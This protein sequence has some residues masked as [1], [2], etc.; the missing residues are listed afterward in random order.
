MAA[1]PDA[2]GYW[3]VANDGG[4]F[5]F[6]DARFDG[7]MGGQRLNAAVVSMGV[8]SDGGGY[9][10]F[11]ADGGVFSFGSAAFAGSSSPPASSSLPVVAGTGA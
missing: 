10:E 6:G 9:W 2:Q 7:S 1:T 8:P 4:I 3:L 11:A 5:A